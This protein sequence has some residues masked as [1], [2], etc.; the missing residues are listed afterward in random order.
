MLRGH[1]LLDLLRAA[2]LVVVVVLVRLQRLLPQFLLAL[3]NVRVEL[4]A[5]LSN[6]K[7][8]VVID[9]DHDLACAHWLIV[10]I[11]ELGHVRVS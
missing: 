10:R 4:V 9:W 5:V 8:L 6:R 1:L 2:A 7:L 3:V 11:V